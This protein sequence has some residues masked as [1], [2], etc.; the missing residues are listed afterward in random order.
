MKFTHPL[1]SCQLIPVFPFTTS[2]LDKMADYQYADETTS[3][4]STVDEYR[5]SE[6][7]LIQYLR[8]R[9]SAY[10]QSAI[11]NITVTVSRFQRVLSFNN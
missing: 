6:Q 2:S 11:N 10:G 3:V 7:V 4:C 9:Y 5:V 8:W 1:C